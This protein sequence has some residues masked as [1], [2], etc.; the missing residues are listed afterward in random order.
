MAHR[1]V[2]SVMQDRAES[3]LMRS[4]A[5]ASLGV[6]VLLVAAKAIAF[7]ATGSVAMLASLADS[8]LDLF[9]ST[10]NLVA[11]RSAL[12]PPDEEHRF[13][14][15]K[16]EPLAG[17]AQGAFIAGSAVFVVIEAINRLLTPRGIDHAREGLIVM[18][19]SI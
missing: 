16:A 14:H 13:G 11:I 2:V 6:S 7:L 4:A 1:T 17:L 15:G 18:A 3:A 19:L 5:F 10:I 8:S 9:T 12:T